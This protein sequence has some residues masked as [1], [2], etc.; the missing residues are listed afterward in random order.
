MPKELVFVGPRK[1]D[2]RDYSDR[3]VQ[4]E[5][6]KLNMLFSGISHGTEMNIYRGTAPL[7]H[8]TRKN[9]LFQEGEPEWKYPM[10]Y[11]YEEVGV[12]TEVGKNVDGFTEG[13]VVACACGH[14]ETGILHADRTAMELPFLRLIP[15]GMNPEHGIFQALG[16]VALDALLTSEIRLGES[17]VILGQ[18]T[19]GLLLLQLCKIAGANTVIVVDPLDSRLVLSEKLG[20]DYVINPKDTDVAV[21]VRNLLSSDASDSRCGGR[22]ADVVF[23]TSGNTKALHE[24][25]RCGAKGYSK[26]IAVGWYQGPAQHLYLGEEFH[27]GLGANRIISV[28]SGINSR[29]PSAP[30]RQWDHIRVVDTLFCLLEQ[31]KLR[32][33]D[34]ISHRFRFEEARKAYEMIDKNPEE[35]MKVVLC[36]NKR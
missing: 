1:I 26:V 10:S 23:E 14:R 19:V 4:D 28:A 29:S 7:F 27:H 34:L 21:D 9:G 18:G 20:A 22:G 12:V 2:F 8:K 5:E 3:P 6:I 11:G 30:V 31:G 24:A 17:A 13:D 32:V 33:E 36:F 25:I 15:K 35:V 16:S